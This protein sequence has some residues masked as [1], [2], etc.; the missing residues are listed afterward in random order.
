MIHL[1]R[2]GAYRKD[3]AKSKEAICLGQ[4]MNGETIKRLML[5]NMVHFIIQVRTLWHGCR[6]PNHGEVNDAITD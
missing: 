5:G 4:K 1:K 2:H 3:I 6:C